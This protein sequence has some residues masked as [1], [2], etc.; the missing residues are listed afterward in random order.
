[1]KPGPELDAL[2][3]EKVMGWIH[4]EAH[5]ASCAPEVWILDDE[6]GTEARKAAEWS[7]STDIADAWEVVEVMRKKDGVFIA[8]MGRRWTVRFTDYS[9]WFADDLPLAICLAALKAK[10]HD[11]L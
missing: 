10:G 9:M 4:L 6:H 11:V 7:P 5:P 1:V 2:V 8:N 3:A